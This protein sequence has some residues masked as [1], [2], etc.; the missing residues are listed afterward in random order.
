MLVSG[1]VSSFRTT[2]IAVGP[3]ALWVSVMQVVSRRWW[4]FEDGVV[5]E[6]ESQ[7]NHGVTSAE[8]YA[9]R[10]GTTGSTDL[11][12]GCGGLDPLEQQVRGGVRQFLQESIE[13]EVTEAL[14][15]RRQGHAVCAKHASEVTVNRSGQSLFRTLELPSYPETSRP[16]RTGL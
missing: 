12:I 15:W 11:L 1:L 3:P 2:D 8:D 10:N 14:G 16:S 9:I 7:R 6:I 5:S 13:Q 4:K